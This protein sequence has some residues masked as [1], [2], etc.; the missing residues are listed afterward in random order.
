MERQGRRAKKKKGSKGKR[1][2]PPIPPRAIN[3][4][5][6]DEEQKGKQNKEVKERNRD[7]GLN[8]ATLAIWLSLTTRMNHSVG[9]FWNHLLHGDIYIYFFYLRIYLFIYLLFKTLNAATVGLLRINAK[10]RHERRA[11]ERKSIEAQSVKPP[12]PS[13]AINALIGDEEQ[14]GK[15]KK[16]TESGSPTQL[17]WS[18]Q[19]IRWTYLFYRPDLQIY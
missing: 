1:K 16:E 8:P 6:G 18:I 12:T 2:K 17:P 19:I 13:R 11:K 7:R 9:L 10:E 14:N 15:R 4:L 3:A 5:I